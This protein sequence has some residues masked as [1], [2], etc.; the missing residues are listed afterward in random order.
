MLS[1]IL[2]FG[3]IR[4]GSGQRANRSV[5]S[6]RRAADEVRRVAVDL[7]LEAE[8]VAVV[9]DRPLDV[10][11]QQDR[12]D[13]RQLHASTLRGELAVG[14]EAL[15]LVVQRA[16]V[17]D[18]LAGRLARPLDQ[19]A[20]GAQA[21]E[22]EVGEA[23]LARA[24]QLALA[25]DV[26]VDLGQLEAVGRPDQRLQP[27][28]AESVS[29]SPGRE[30]SRQYDCSAPRPTR[31]RSWCSWA[32]PKRSASWTIM[33]VAFG[34]STPTS[35]TVVATSTSSSPR[36]ELRHQLAPLRRP[37]P[38][39]QEPDAVAAQLALP[40][41]LGLALGGPRAPTSPT[42]RS[43]GRRRT[44]GGPSSR[45]LRSR[46]YASLERSSVTQ[47]VTIGLRFAGGFA[48]SLTERSP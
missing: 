42:P 16:G 8:P 43:A 19:V 41:P 12:R 11:D 29:S 15:D 10:G 30:T 26:E 2:Q 3:T 24:E 46:L 37:Q 27:R 33:I 13:A 44:P 7:A 34:T 6:S 22:A 14:E 39:V 48:I 1:T 20:V 31:P 21:R 40:Q 28:R 25:A 35:I 36:L 9:L 18:E 17:V 5:A 4:S 23:G 45:C 47:A 38:P 32:R